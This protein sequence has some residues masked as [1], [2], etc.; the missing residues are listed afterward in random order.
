MCSRVCE[1]CTHKLDCIANRNKTG[2]VALTCGTG[3]PST[4]SIAVRSKWLTQAGAAGCRE[5]TMGSGPSLA[6]PAVPNT[7]RPLLLHSD[8][9]LDMS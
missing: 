7:A 5:R 1:V 4:G 2:Q 8:K 9:L 3:E 6:H